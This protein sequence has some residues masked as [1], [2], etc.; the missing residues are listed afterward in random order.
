[1]S[2]SRAAAL[3]EGFSTPRALMSFLEKT[4]A[5]EAIKRMASLKAGPSC[6]TTKVYKVLMQECGVYKIVTLRSYR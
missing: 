4:P 1:M 6:R 3:C 5:K 2:A